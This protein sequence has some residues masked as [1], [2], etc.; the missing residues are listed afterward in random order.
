AEWRLMYDGPTAF[1]RTPSMAEGAALASTIGA[2]DGMAGIDAAVDLRAD[3]VTVRLSWYSGMTEQHVSLAQR[4]S[5]TAHQ[6]GAEPDA[7]RLQV[8][9]VT[10]DALS[11]PDVVAFWRAV[12]DYHEIGDDDLIDPRGRGPTV[13][14][15]DMDAPRRQRNRMHVDLSLPLAEAEAR[16]KAALAAGGTLVSDA[17]A[18]M[19][20]TLADPEGNEV[21]IAAHP[22]LV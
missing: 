13:W 1:F 21:D 16:V 14:F 19:W 9:Q 4:I 7:S 15:Q 5:A 20:W 6:A 10:V 17:H 18:P 3:G 11:I 22:D 12:L 2:L 8:V